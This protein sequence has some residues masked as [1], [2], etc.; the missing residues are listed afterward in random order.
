MANIQKRGDSY[1]I[2]VSDGFD[3]ETGARR[4]RTMTWTPEPGMTEN[5]IEKELKRQAVL[6]E[7]FCRKQTAEGD[8]MSFDAF[9]K[10]WRKEYAVVQFKNT[11]LAYYDDLLRRI[12]PALGHLKLS[13]ITPAHISRFYANLRERG[14][15]TDVHYSPKVDFRSFI[16]ENNISRQKLADCSGI[17]M[18][19]LES[20]ISGKNV[21]RKTAEKLCEALERDVGELFTSV[22]KQ[23]TFSSKTLLHYHRAL[24]AI[25]NKAVK[26]GCMFSNP[27]DRVDAPKLNRREARYLNEE[28]TTALLK[29]LSDA[30]LQ[31]RV[32]INLMVFTGARRGEI[33]GLEWS[34]IDSEAHKLHIR[35]NSLYLPGTGMYED[36]TKTEGSDRT[37][38]IPESLIK[39]LDELKAYQ[40]S[41]RTQAGDAWQD[42][43]KVFTQWNGKPIHPSTI[44]AW[45][46]KHCKQNGL[47]HTTPH[48]LR[49]TSA[50]LLLMQGVPLKAV[51]KRLGHTLASTTSDIYGH[52]LPSIDDIAA[53]TL[54]DLLN[55][56]DALKNKKD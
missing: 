20:L 21:S 44:S 29:S 40:D 19:T 6:F 30:P 51:S 54:D 47:P 23:R 3:P 4:Y 49:H 45:L 14:I 26:W 13:E 25:F 32:M 18:T 15:C 28:Q 22:D 53:D 16:A 12:L 55:P 2:R 38:S 42:S 36:T 31:Y 48:M 50:T 8:G 7:E 43:R 35:R 34:D 24:S 46:R 17:S 37:I 41:V 27:C 39:M 11:T 1:R 33:C 5:Q 52:S 9:V 10:R 56:G